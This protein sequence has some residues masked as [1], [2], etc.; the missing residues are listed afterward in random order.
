MSTI[1]KLLMAALT[2]FT[3]CDVSA[4]GWEK[5]ENLPET[6]FSVI[7]EIDGTLYAA[8]G[9]TL[10]TSQD[11]G[12]SW[13]DSEFT[14]DEEVTII[15]LTGFGDK[16]YAG[17]TDGVYSAPSDAVHDSEWNHDIF[18]LPVTSFAKKDDT[19]YASVY[20]FGAMV[21]NGTAW[22]NFSTGLPNNSQNV[23][24]LVAT[25]EALF[26]LAGGNGTF[27]KYDFAAGSWEEHFYNGDIEAGVT[28]DDGLAVG[29]TLYAC[30]GS[31]ILRSDD[32]GET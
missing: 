27:Y 3:A 5:L 28:M 21:L 26:A 18:T 30:N 4:Q 12:E 2:F 20:G 13:T 6:E 19:L 25:D 22:M 9:N 29:T 17:T 23:A 24:K 10:Y 15:C 31:T 11:N 14:N 8:S 1:L 16:I 32:G 7:T